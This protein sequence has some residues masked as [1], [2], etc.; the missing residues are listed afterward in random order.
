MLF[1]TT[2]SRFNSTSY[3]YIEL[4]KFMFRDHNYMFKVGETTPV[5]GDVLMI[6][7][8]FIMQ[9]VLFNMVRAIIA[10]AYFIV[11]SESIVELTP[12]EMLQEKH[13]VNKV[14]DQKD[15]LLNIIVKWVNE[16]KA[17]EEKR[18][19]TKKAKAA[20]FLNDHI[21]AKLQPKVEKKDVQAKERA[22]WELIQKTFRERQ[23]KEIE[24]IKAST[25][26]EQLL[27]RIKN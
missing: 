14:Y 23:K 27:K 19:N 24:L 16:N 7:F 17:D 5:V 26:K 12:D 8:L 20:Q 18:V 3:T 15:P 13:L 9:F 25:T 1:G 2:Y 11:S 21:I 22:R 10:N 4:W 6:S